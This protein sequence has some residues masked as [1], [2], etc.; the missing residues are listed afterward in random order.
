MIVKNCKFNNIKVTEDFE[1]FGRQTKGVC[2]TLA[3]N[4]GALTKANQI[5]NCVFN[6]VRLNKG[7][8]IAAIEFPDR[9]FDIVTEISDC[10]F[11]RCTTKRESG[12]IIK[13]YVGY[14]PVIDRT[15][16]D[17]HANIISG[18]DGLNQ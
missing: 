13:E 7:F 4:K 14:Y 2:I 16:K 10:T 11:E 8:L 17:F 1:K 18:C 9:P 3:R 6:G 15:M 12:K 5:S